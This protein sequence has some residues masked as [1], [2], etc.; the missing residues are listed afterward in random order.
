[1]LSC[2]YLCSLKL[3]LFRLYF[4]NTFYYNYFIPVLPKPVSPRLVSGNLPTSTGGKTHIG[5]KINCAN[6]VPA[7]MG[8]GIEVLLYVLTID[9]NKTY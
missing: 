9:N 4:H 8:I 7:F 6:L 3:I 2:Q 5:N 1:M